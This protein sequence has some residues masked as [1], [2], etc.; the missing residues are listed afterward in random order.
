MQRYRDTVD[1]FFG[2]EHRM[3]KE[4]MVEQFNKEVKQGWRFLADAARITDDNARSE[5]CKHT[6]RRVSV[7]N[8]ATRER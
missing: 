8:T 1:I 4:E 7:A 2:T 5:D 6:S 3:R